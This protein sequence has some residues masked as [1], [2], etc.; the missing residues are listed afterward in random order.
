[1][2]KQRNLRRGKR[3]T[4]KAPVGAK[5]ARSGKK[6]SPGLCMARREFLFYRCCRP[7]GTPCRE[8]ILRLLCGTFI[9]GGVRGVS[10]Y[11]RSRYSSFPRLHRFAPWRK[12][13]AVT[14]RLPAVCIKRAAFV[15]ACFFAASELSAC[16]ASEFLASKREVIFRASMRNPN[17]TTSVNAAAR[18]NAIAKSPVNAPARIES[19]VCAMSSSVGA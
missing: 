10:R 11:S 8:L 14:N 7:H 1:M 4:T 12:S 6:W 18:S 19:A 9:R 5:A 3:R 13:L 16:A 15:R 17:A 2:K